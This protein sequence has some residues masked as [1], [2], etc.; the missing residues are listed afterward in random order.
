VQHPNK[1]WATD[2]TYV[3]TWQGWHYLALVLDPYARKVVGWSMQSTLAKELALY[4]L[5]MAVWRHK[6]KE[7][8]IINSGQ[9]SQDGSD[10]WQ[11]FCQQHRLV[12]S[13]SR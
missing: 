5:L 4:A 13:M 7:Q 1:V 11:R 6:P 8:I 2:I 10:D 9:G 12:P 3:H